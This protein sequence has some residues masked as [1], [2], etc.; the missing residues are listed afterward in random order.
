MTLKAALLACEDA[1]V[2][3]FSIL[4]TPGPIGVL[5]PHTIT[6]TP[7]GNAVEWPPHSIEDRLRFGRT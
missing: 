7:T 6:V 1:G 3:R 5:S 4:A 2:V